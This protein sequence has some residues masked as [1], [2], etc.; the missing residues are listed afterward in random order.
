MPSGE[1][2]LLVENCDCCGTLYDIYLCYTAQDCMI[3]GDPPN[4]FSADITCEDGSVVTV[5]LSRMNGSPPVSDFCEDSDCG[6]QIFYKGSWRIR[7]SVDSLGVS[8]DGWCD[9]ASAG[10]RPSEGP[11]LVGAIT[12]DGDSCASRDCAVLV[13][14]EPCRGAF[15]GDIQRWKVMPNFPSGCQPSNP[16]Q[17]P[18]S[19]DW[20]GRAEWYDCCHA[21]GATFIAPNGDTYAS[22]GQYYGCWS[23]VD[24]DIQVTVSFSCILWTECPD[25]VDDVWVETP[26]P[27]CEGYAQRES[28]SGDRITVTYTCTFMSSALSSYVGWDC[29]D[30]ISVS[31][32]MAYVYER[33]KGHIAMQF[34]IVFRKTVDFPPRYEADCGKGVDFPAH[35]WSLCVSSDHHDIVPCYAGDEANVFNGVSLYV[36][37]PFKEIVPVGSCS[38]PTC[39]LDEN[40]GDVSDGDFLGN[41]LDRYDYKIIRTYI[42]SKNYKLWID[43]GAD[44]NGKQNKLLIKAGTRDPGGQIPSEAM[45]TIVAYA[46]EAISAPDMSSYSGFC[47]WSFDPDCTCDADPPCASLTFPYATMP[48][49]DG[50]TVY[51]IFADVYWLYAYW[52]AP[53]ARLADARPYAAGESISVSSLQVPIQSCRPACAASGSWI[54]L[55]NP[56]DPIPATM[57]QSDLEVEYE[58][59]ADETVYIAVFNA[60]PGLFQDG[61]QTKTVTGKCGDPIPDPGTPW[62]GIQGTSYGNYGPNRFISWSPAVPTTFGRGNL[63]FTALYSN[64]TINLGDVTSFI[65]SVPFQTGVTFIGTLPSNLRGISVV[66]NAEITLGGAII[67]GR[68]GGNDASAGINLGC[69]TVITLVGNNTVRRYAR[70]YSGEYPAIYVP[71]NCTLTIR[72][73]GSLTTDG[74]GGGENLA[75]GNIIIESGTITVEYNNVGASIGGG[76]HSSFGDITITGGIISAAGGVEAAGIGSS[77]QGSSCGNITITGGSITAKGGYRSPGIG[78]GYYHAACGSITITDAVTIVTAEKG[79]NAPY[80]IGRG[81][82]SDCGTVT[83]GGV[84]GERT[85]DPYIYQP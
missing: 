44:C 63:S 1:W 5:P 7:G 52:P 22:N 9:S 28:A 41:L 15:T 14:S 76:L 60:Y 49:S 55:S 13:A 30:G 57:P 81:E 45:I 11:S 73:N 83:I 75:G 71:P 59:V 34:P 20:Y 18:L 85:E 36:G 74:I 58:W 62:L 48:N 10:L 29:S 39:I 53:C 43:V 35:K 12:V 26:F 38:E 19:L 69:N 6:V 16:Q 17:Y 8:L 67:P 40:I 2:V 3:C 80:S 77:G 66:P 47:G 50:E 32:G 82:Q 68:I 56:G 25:L 78:S 23:V 24:P 64:V 51:A 65:Q 61:S 31:G 21:N 37:S 79:P 72:G 4:S 84:V 33:E 70:Q 27:G 42:D 46:G 54:N